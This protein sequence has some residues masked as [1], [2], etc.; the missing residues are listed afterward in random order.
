MNLILVLQIPLYLTLLQ[1]LYCISSETT[2]QVIL[3]VCVFVYVCACMHACVR[4]CMCVYVKMSGN[5][6]IQ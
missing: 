5:I 1:W 6:K 3:N 2:S 4:A